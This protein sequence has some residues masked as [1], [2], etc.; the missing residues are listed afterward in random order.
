MTTLSN[1]ISSQP[2]AL[3]TLITLASAATLAFALQQQK[4]RAMPK[5]YLS[6]ESMIQA[7]GPPSLPEG[8]E[9]G[10]F[11]NKRSQSNF[12]IHLPRVDTSVPPK[13]TLVLI[14]GTAE[15]CCRN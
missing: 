14:H 12:T 6:K 9:I 1:K 15:H 5:N 4:K 13:A 11:T 3:I 7:A 2:A 8:F 10:S